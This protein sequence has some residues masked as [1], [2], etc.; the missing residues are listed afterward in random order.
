MNVF[1]SRQRH[2][3]WVWQVTA[4]CFMLGMLVAGS[5]QTVSIV[6]RTGFGGY[7]TGVPPPGA[8]AHTATVQKL[9]KEI[10]DLRERA[11]KLENSLAKGNDQLKTLNDELQKDK[12]L[13]GLTEVK[14]P[15]IDLVL[16]DS[17]KRPPSNRAFDAD[18]YII[19]DVDL[20][21]VVNEL[22]A[23]GAEAIAIS[24]QRVTSRT[25]IRCV[26][27]TI[28][29]NGV[30][31][32]PPYSIAAIG[33]PSTLAGALNLPYGVLDG[34]RRYDPAMFKLEKRQKLVLPAFT[35]STETRYARPV[36]DG[37]SAGSGPRRR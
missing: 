36:V 20:Q 27:P 6:G 33:D 25:S 2:Q 17:E 32:S 14:G 11:T 24:N 21:Q 22:W 29:V 15:G 34:L 19:H 10:A 28:Q 26:G 35:G 18:K 1:T 7:R 16:V 12:L 4:L 31:V 30:P 9:E 23:S 8:A 37:E 3:P 5:L 13:A